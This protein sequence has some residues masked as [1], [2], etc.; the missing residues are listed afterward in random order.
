MS[1][2]VLVNCGYEA[3]KTENATV[4][5]IVAN[6]AAA[7]ENETVVF[8]TSDSVKLG[9]K[10][11]A[12]NMNAEGHEPLVNYI[13]TFVEN[14][15]QLWVCPACAGTRGITEDDLIEGALWRGA[16]PVIDFAKQ[17]TNV[18]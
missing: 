4:A 6:A 7:A 8:L 11:G 17:A 5:M 14:G 16:M 2:K 10:N 3:D 12:D 9:I 13:S 18:F 15:G 1:D